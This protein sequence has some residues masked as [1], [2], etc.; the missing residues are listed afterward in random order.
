[1]ISY[2]LFVE[3]L[4][5]GV[6]N[7]DTN[8]YQFKIFESTMAPRCYVG[9]DFGSSKIRISSLNVDSSVSSHDIRILPTDGRS[10]DTL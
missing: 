9:I 1:M 5:F 6:P 7:I 2:A 10:I 4:K 8:D 3:Y